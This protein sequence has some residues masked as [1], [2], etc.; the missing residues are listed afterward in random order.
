MTAIAAKSDY[1]PSGPVYLATALFLVLVGNLAI[2]ASGAVALSD[3]SLN[4]P[5]SYMRLLRVTQLYESGDWFDHT[6][7]RSNAPY[8]EVLH[9]TRPADLLHLSGALLLEPFFGFDRA[10]YLWAIV[11]SPLLFVAMML[12]L[13]WAMAPLLDDLGRFLLILALITEAAIWPHGALGRTDHHMLIMLVFAASLGGAIRVMATSASARTALLAGAAA[14]FGLWLSVEFLV[15]WAI[16]FGALTVCWITRDGQGGDQARRNLW[17]ALG[18]AGV[19]LL[20]LAVERLPSDWFAEAYDRVSVAH[21]LVALLAAAFW[22]VAAW[23]TARLPA[24]GTPGGRIAVGAGGAVC[25]GAVLLLTF[26]KF[27]G[28]PEVDYDPGLKDIFLDR[29]SETRSL[30]P[31]SV[32]QTGWLLFYL[33][34]A[35]FAVP[36]VLWRLWRHRG[37]E[38]WYGWMLIAL[39]LLVYLPLAI[40][41][42][43]F[44]GLAAM[45]LAV[46]VA[47]LLGA[48]LAQEDDGQGR[49]KRLLTLGLA[50]PAV[51]FGGLAVGGILLKQKSALNAPDS[52][53]VGPLVTELNRPDGLGRTPLTVLALLNFG[54]QL[55]YQTRHRVVA[56]PYPRNAQG[57]LDAVRI[58]AATDPEESRRLVE[59]REIDVIATCTR[60]PTYWDISEDPASLDSRL[61][62]GELPAWLRAVKLDEGTREEIGLFQVVPTDTAEN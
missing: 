20:A 62:R 15:A 52:C 60:R 7:P 3:G 5:D 6:I 25:A 61:R 34:Q 43:R 16:I 35:V 36:Y 39:G 23:L 18:M 24:A 13:V 45:L 9:W 47:G 29:V 21:L 26:P 57:Q 46:A 11:T 41:M 1:R 10:L 59:A 31:D 58:F 49:L 33:G 51:L 32:S 4:G 28:G 12:A 54:P 17:H 48:L 38:T 37:E 19:V 50:V 27:L 42:R 22:G 8:G 30:L 56:T 2:V 55:M 40:Y 14:G 53:S 44:G